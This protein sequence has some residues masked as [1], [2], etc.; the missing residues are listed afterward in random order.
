MFD[1]VPLL[2]KGEIDG[3]QCS[4]QQRNKRGRRLRCR[5]KTRKGARVEGGKGGTGPP[6]RRFSREP[7]GKEGELRGSA[8]LQIARG[9]EKDSWDGTFQRLKGGVRPE[10]TGGETGGAVVLIPYL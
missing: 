9:K 5:K 6:R 8:G 2:Q 7:V 4:G 1:Q 3:L 10:G